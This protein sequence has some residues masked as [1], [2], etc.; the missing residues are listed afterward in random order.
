MWSVK[1][2]RLQVAL[3]EQ[4]VV[5]D[6]SLQLGGQATVLPTGL[7]P[8]D[9]GPR[10]AGGVAALERWL[11]DHPHKGAQMQVHLSAQ[12]VRWLC[13]PWPLGLVQPDALQAYAQA[14]LRATFGAA[15]EQ[16]Q[17]VTAPPQPGQAVVACAMDQALI[18]ALQAL[19]H[20]HGLKLDHVGP[21]FAA[22]HDHWHPQLQRGTVWFAGLEPSAMTVGLLHKGQWLGLRSVRLAGQSSEDWPTVLGALQRQMRIGCDLGADGEGDT[23]GAWPVYVSGALGA[24]HPAAQGHTHLVPPTRE[25]AMAADLAWA[26]MAWGV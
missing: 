25:P 26:R 12:L 13:L 14:R 2:Q 24:G 7:A 23:E 21:Y 8:G 20:T 1:R 15:A 9:A 11:Q 5:V 22:A 10:W 18:E 16:W 6:T 19:A 4:Q 3:L 17:L